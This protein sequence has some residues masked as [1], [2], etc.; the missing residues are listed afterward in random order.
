MAPILFL[1]LMQ[2]IAEMLLKLWSNDRG[3]L[4]DLTPFRHHTTTTQYRGPSFLTNYSLLQQKGTTFFDLLYSLFVDD[5][6]FICD[7]TED[8]RQC[9]QEIHSTFKR[10]VG[11]LMHSGTLNL[12]TNRYSASKTEAMYFPASLPSGTSDVF[13]PPPII[14]GGDQHQYRITLN[15]KLHNHGADSKSRLYSQA[16]PQDIND[17]CQGECYVVGRGYATRHILSTQGC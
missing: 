16:A 13:T 1:F 15:D 10:F 6:A 12:E 2:A 14:Y 5:G 11:L 4:V 9:T 7:S 3:R 8:L 17:I